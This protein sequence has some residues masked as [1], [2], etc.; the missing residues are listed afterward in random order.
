MALLVFAE[1]SIICTRTLLDTKTN[2]TFTVRACFFF[3]FVPDDGNKR[4][5][6][7]E[8]WPCR[9]M[10]PILPIQSISGSRLLSSPGTSG[11]SW[12]YIQPN[13]LCESSIHSIPG[14]FWT[15]KRDELTSMALTSGMLCHSKCPL[16]KDKL[17]SATRPQNL[18]IWHFGIWH[19]TR[20]AFG[21]YTNI[22]QTLVHPL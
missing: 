6:E 9:V 11:M 20:V 1:G 17:L 19:R 16:W 10:L 12:N 13:L 15:Y 5:P 3:P 4:D 7:R 21:R 8:N 18:E 22:H 14:R 2:W